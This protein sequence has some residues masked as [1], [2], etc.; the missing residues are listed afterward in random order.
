MKWK[1][2]GQ[3]ENPPAGEH[4]ARCFQ[5]VDMGTQPHT[6]DGIVTLRRDVKIVFELPLCPMTGKYNPESKGRPFAVSKTFKQSLHT[7]SA[8][9]PFLESWRGKKFTREEIA[10]YDPRKLVGAPCKLTL[11][12][13]GEYVNIDHIAK[14]PPNDCPKMVNEPLFVSL[15]PTEFKPEDF[16]RLSEKMQEKIKASPEYQALFAKKPSVDET[17]A[18]EL[19]PTEAEEDS[20]PF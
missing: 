10:A 19:H 5:L 1:E 13:N 11:I 18:D 6:F 9:R 16:G 3:F 7:A 2:G 12:E 8:L 20:T 4:I 14:L 17:A 15:D